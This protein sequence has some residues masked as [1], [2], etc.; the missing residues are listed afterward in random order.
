MIDFMG[1]KYII[2]FSRLLVTISNKGLKLHSISTH[3]SNP[4]NPQVRTAS[5]P[6][7]WAPL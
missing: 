6:T 4:V 3:A 7:K 1:L 2:G 5:S